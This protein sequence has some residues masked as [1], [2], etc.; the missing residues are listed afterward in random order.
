M[1]DSHHFDINVV[2]ICIVI[3]IANYIIILISKTRPREN[4]HLPKSLKFENFK[5]LHQ[6][7]IL[8]RLVPIIALVLSNTFDRGADPETPLWTSGGVASAAAVDDI[9]LL[10]ECA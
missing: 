10:T 4:S 9:D 6:K 1:E 7:M 5:I 8:K 3:L 2:S